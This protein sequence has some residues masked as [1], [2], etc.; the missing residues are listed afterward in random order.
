MSQSLE[1]FLKQIADASK[2]KEE[3]KKASIQ[4]FNMLLYA[5][6]SKYIATDILDRIKNDEHIVSYAYILHDKDFYDVDT[7][8]IH[9]KLLGKQG[10]H[11]KNH[12]HVC[13]SLNNKTPI[14]D[15]ALWLGVP[16][17]FIQKTK[18][19]KGSI[20]YLTHK[21]A[22]DKH[23]YSV[24][25]VITN[26]SEYHKY[27]YDNYEPRR[28]VIPLLFSYLAS[29]DNPT[30]TDFIKYYGVDHAY[31]VRK[32]WALARDI[33]AEN[34]NQMA[35]LQENYKNDLEFHRQHQQG[36]G[37]LLEQFKKVSYTDDTGKFHQ[38]TLND[39]GTIDLCGYTV[40]GNK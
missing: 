32:M 12:Y 27:L 7:F 30:Y 21:N 24:N 26:I 10:E 36:L 14:S 1:N 5:D 29:T 18:D 6:D 39:D 33:I 3:P 13:V 25:D 31:E 34:K 19:F 9:G 40:G 15:I 38:V 4:Q 2:K 35:R 16:Q 8:D 17:R 28:D 20:L 22:P 37:K 23:Q 11:K